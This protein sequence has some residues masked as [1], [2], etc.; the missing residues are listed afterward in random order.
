MI[1]I[2]ISHKRTSHWRIRKTR[3]LKSHEGKFLCSNKALNTS[4]FS[5][6]AISRQLHLNVSQ[7][8]HS[9]NKI[10]MRWTWQ[11]FVPRKI[12][13]N[14]RTSRIS[15]ILWNVD[16]GTYFSHIVVTMFLSRIHVA[17][18]F[19]V[20]ST[21]TNRNHSSVIIE[22]ST[23]TPGTSQSLN[24]NQ[25]FPPTK[26]ENKIIIASVESWSSSAVN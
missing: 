14:F 19:L 16:C 9:L 24:S 21:V 6:S 20:L 15:I 2:S 18:G 11:C 8:S 23:P 26:T 4:Y 22:V 10:I 17:C 7:H 3:V 12:H 1:W 13:R 25:I 5:L